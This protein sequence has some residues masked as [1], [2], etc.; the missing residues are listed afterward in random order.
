MV[1]LELPISILASH[2]SNSGGSSLS[3][4]RLEGRVSLWQMR[5]QLRLAPQLGAAPALFAW[6]VIPIFGFDRYTLFKL[7]INLC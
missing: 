7:E 4:Y 2:A 6:L 1:S 3:P 5:C